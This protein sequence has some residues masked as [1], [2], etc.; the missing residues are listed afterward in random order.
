MHP[1]SDGWC[2]KGSKKLFTARF[3]TKTA[4]DGISSAGAALEAAGAVSAYDL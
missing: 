4:E 1:R 2:G 3:F